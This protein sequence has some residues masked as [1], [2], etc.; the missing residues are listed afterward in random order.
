[1]GSGSPSVTPSVVGSSQSRRGGG[2][3]GSRLKM[4]ACV[5]VGGGCLAKEQQ[6]SS[7]S[8]ITLAF[9]L[10][11]KYGA[12][13]HIVPIVQQGAVRRPPP[14]HCSFSAARRRKALAKN[15]VSGQ[16]RALR[17]RQVYSRLPS[18]PSAVG[19]H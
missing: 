12:T 7:P 17:P 8:R 10:Y 3:G 11:V 5:W 4:E 13:T 2:G 14:P 18:C 1:M 15:E 9:Q 6:W 19:C 16:I